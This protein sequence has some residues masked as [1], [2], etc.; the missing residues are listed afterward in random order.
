MSHHFDTATARE[1]P[2]LNLLDFYLFPGESGTTVMPL[3]VKPNA[4]AKAPDTFHEEGIN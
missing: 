2:R 4:G 1:D 3:T